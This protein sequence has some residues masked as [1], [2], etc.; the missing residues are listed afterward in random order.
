MAG[1]SDPAGVQRESIH[2]AARSVTARRSSHGYGLSP[3]VH[4]LGFIRVERAEARAVA[5]AEGGVERPK[6]Y[7]L[8]FGRRVVH[9]DNDLP[10][11]A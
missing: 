9:L 3:I 4:T 5:V 2:T 1:P 10:S 7:C 6:S 8:L 11:A